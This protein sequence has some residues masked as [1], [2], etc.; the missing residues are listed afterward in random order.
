MSPPREEAIV[1]GEPHLT[2][3]DEDADAIGELL[4]DLLLDALA[5]APID[6]P[7]PLDPEVYQDSGSSG[8]VLQ[9]RGAAR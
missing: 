3:R 2:V 8:T 4:A 6:A 5:A 9:A 7:R 1:E